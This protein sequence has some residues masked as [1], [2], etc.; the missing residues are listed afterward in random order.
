MSEISSIVSSAVAMQLARSQ[1]QIALSLIRA[2]AQAEQEVA[3]MIMQ[4]ARQI[5]V[6][7]QSI[8]IGTIDL[9]I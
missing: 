1:D 4:N 2:S 6:L 7:S 8:Q 9:Y 5:E 3:D